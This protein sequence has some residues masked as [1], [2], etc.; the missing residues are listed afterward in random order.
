MTNQEI[1]FDTAIALNI[2]TE[3]QAIEHLKQSGELP[4]HTFKEWQRLGYCVKK[5]EKAA[6]ICDIWRMTN[7]KKNSATDDKEEEKED[8]FYMKTAYFFTFDQV[9]KINKKVSA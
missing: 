6:M 9:E 4:L 1:I 2:F 8:H 3:D 5:G 7:Y